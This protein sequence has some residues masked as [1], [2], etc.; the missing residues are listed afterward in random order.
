MVFTLTWL[1][2]LGLHWMDYFES[3]T[4]ILLHWIDYIKL[5]KLNTVTLYA[6]FTLHWLGWLIT[7]HLLTLNW[8]H[9]FLYTAM[10]HVG[11]IA[12]L[13]NNCLHYFIGDTSR[14]EWVIYIAP[15]ETRRRPQRGRMQLDEPSSVDDWRDE[16]RDGGGGPSVRVVGLSD[17]KAMVGEEHVSIYTL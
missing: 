3:I 16:S 12:F 2:W 11:L 10:N 1:H 15:F 7:L 13:G 5:I 8:W 17:E 6:V 4:L 14:S 9:W